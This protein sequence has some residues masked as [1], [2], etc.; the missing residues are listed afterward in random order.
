MCE[1][2]HLM[3]NKHAGVTIGFE[4]E[5]YTAGESDG[6]AFVVAVV[7]AGQLATG[8]VVDFMTEPM[9]A[10]GKKTIDSTAQIHALVYSTF[11]L[12]PFLKYLS[13]SRL[14]DCGT[15]VDI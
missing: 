13:T 6:V 12:S 14:P 4:E 5:T 1:V 10:I 7:L 15:T 9:T 3:D 11:N 2:T 8:V